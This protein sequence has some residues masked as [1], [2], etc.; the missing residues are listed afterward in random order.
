MRFPSRND[1]LQ[2]DHSHCSPYLVAAVE[3][4]CIA[5]TALTWL[6]L[7]SAGMAFTE[8]SASV[9]LGLMSHPQR[10]EQFNKLWILIHR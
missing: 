10:G 1:S 3:G 5:H 7:P 9:F 8:I 4:G 2:N 6:L